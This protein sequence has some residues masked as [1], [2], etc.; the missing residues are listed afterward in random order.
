MRDILVVVIT[1]VSVW[2]ITGLMCSYFDS[3]KSEKQ[4]I[5]SKV[6]IEVALLYLDDKKCELESE[7]E[8]WQS[9][10]CVWIVSESRMMENDDIISRQDSIKQELQKVIQLIKNL[11]GIQ[12]DYH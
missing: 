12:E 7:L 3:R 4:S 6:I 1:A 2:I 10:D 5:E 9:G 11:E 8:K